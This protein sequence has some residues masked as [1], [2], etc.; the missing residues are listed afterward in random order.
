MD[1]EP[2]VFIV[3]GDAKARRA[4][5][6]RMESLELEAAAFRTPDEF[7]GVHAPASAGCMLLHVSAEASELDLLQDLGPRETHLPVVVIASRGDVPTAVRAMQ[8]GAMNFLEESCS[9][10]RLAA[11]I[12]DALRWDSENRRRLTHVQHVRRRLARLAQPHRAVL[13]LL[14]A[15]KSNRE[16]AIELKR[17]VRTIEERRSTVMETM[18]ARSFAELVR[19][20]MLVEEPGGPGR[21]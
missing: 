18:R 17:S 1:G 19:L 14:L 2:R 8:L 12:G 16:I 20:A 7:F 11:A 13:D 10:D 21:K 3:A 4:L 15:G 5:A 9:D 6:V